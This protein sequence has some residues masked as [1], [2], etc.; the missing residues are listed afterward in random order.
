MEREQLYRDIVSHV[1]R[2]DLYQVGQADQRAKHGCARKYKQQSA[3]NLRASGEDLIRPGSADGRPENPHRREIAERLDQSS[4]KRERHLERSG[5]VDAVQQQLRGKGEADEQTKPLM[6][7][8]VVLAFAVE[9]GPDSGCE[10]GADQNAKRQDPVERFVAAAAPYID[11]WMLDLK[12]MR[13]GEEDDL[14]HRPERGRI[15]HLDFR[16]GKQAAED[17]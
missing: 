11:Q 13:G 3:Q 17:L 5:F 4:E 8:D 16:D 10:H 7:R 14:A 1:Q 2:E 6:Q 15:W 12:N 9:N